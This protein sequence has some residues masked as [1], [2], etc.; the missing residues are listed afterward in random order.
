MKLRSYSDGE[1]EGGE[2]AAGGT[3]ATKIG[4]LKELPSGFRARF[5]NGVVTYFDTAMSDPATTP[6][7]KATF[8]KT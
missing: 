2:N 1:A 6:H 3:I 4:A 5:E 7:A 8:A